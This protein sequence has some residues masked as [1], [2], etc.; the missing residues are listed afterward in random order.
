MINNDIQSNN[1]S[2]MYDLIRDDYTKYGNASS[3]RK[4]DLI[5]SRDALLAC[6]SQC[7][8]KE[9]DHRRRIYSEFSR[10]V[11]KESGINFGIIEKNGPRVIIKK[12][13]SLKNLFIH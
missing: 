5:F 3:D 10:F 7:N 8:D 6:I 12:K 1:S 13:K 2:A 4:K 9:E 11:S